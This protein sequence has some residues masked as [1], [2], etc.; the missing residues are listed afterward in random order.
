MNT[1]SEREHKVHVRSAQ[2]KNTVSPKYSRYME[3][4][5][6]KSKKTAVLTFNTTHQSH[7]HVLF[8]M[9]EVFKIVKALGPR[10]GD[11][12]ICVEKF[13]SETK[14]TNS[15]NTE[16]KAMNFNGVEEYVTLTQTSITT[17]RKTSMKL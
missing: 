9:L 5:Q 7:P 12:T 4:Q 2:K 14:K 1:S 10:N 6:S 17:K 13:S 8:H 11:I 15:L 3:S 16:L